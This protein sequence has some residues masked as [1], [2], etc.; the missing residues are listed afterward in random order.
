MRA[1]C[2]GGLLKFFFVNMVSRGGKQV[3]SLLSP[4][5]L[6]LFLSPI[7]SLSLSLICKKTTT[8]KKA[9][10]QKEECCF[11][12]HRKQSKP[13]FVFSFL[14]SRKKV[15]FFLRV[16]FEVV[17]RSLFLLSFAAEPVGEFS[18]EGV[19]GGVCVCGWVGV[20]GVK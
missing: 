1:L 14:F 19:G 15:G 7:L 13:F 20:G 9:K 4:K 5:S 18:N 3:F 8:E 16:F 11:A 2:S 17:F 12:L 6:S 10:R